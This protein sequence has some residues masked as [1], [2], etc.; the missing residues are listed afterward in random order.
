MPPSIVLV[1]L[2][3]IAL[4]HHVGIKQPGILPVTSLEGTGRREKVPCEP[5]N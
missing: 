3:E 4:E 1:S 2:S 5:A